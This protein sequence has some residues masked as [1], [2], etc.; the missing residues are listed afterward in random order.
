MQAQIPTQMGYQIQG[1][2]QGQMI[3]QMQGQMPFQMQGQM[4]TQIPVQ[5]PFQMQ[6]QMLAQKPI[7]MQGQP[8]QMQGQMPIQIPGQPT[9]MSQMQSQ[10]IQMQSQPTQIQGQMPV[11]LPIQ[12]PGQPTLMSQNY[13]PIN[14]NM[15]NQYMINPGRMSYSNGNGLM[16]NMYQQNVGHMIYNNNAPITN[17][18]NT[19]ETC[20]Y[21]GK[22]NNSSNHINN[23]GNKNDDKE[24]SVLARNTVLIGD[25]NAPTGNGII[26]IFFEASTGSRAVINVSENTPI[27]EVLEKYAEKINLHKNYL[28]NK[29]IFLLFGKKIDPS[30][31]APIKSINIK[32]GNSISVFDQQNVLGA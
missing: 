26:N 1:Q 21:Y 27:K 15:N 20:D 6:G 22:N 7:Q 14:T 3:P 17:S 29:V 32:N 18:S 8:T 23:Q 28:G 12:M 30:S 19:D 24:E 11:Q 25:P 4:P 31:T 5:M 9:L 10:P 16:M 13:Q 2:M